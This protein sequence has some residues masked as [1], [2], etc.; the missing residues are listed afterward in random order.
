MLP[1]FKGRI[2]RKTFF[3]GNIAG[4]MVLGFAGLIYIVPLAIIDIV[5]NKSTVSPVFKILYA[6]FLIPAIFY[7]FYFSVLF[8]KRMHDI[9]FPGL[10]LLW[11]FIILEGVA[12]VADIWMLNIAGF[13]ILL[14][15]CFLPGQ[16]GRNN[17]GPKPGKKFKTD[18]IVVRF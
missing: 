9:G 15:V 16:R 13:V 18:D 7:F 10:L 6:L 1:A 5:V 12:R 11:T 2:N 17:F 3:M 14:A 8:V 4:L